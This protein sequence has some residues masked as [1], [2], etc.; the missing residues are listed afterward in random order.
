MQRQHVGT[1]AR[2]EQRVGYARAV[3]V[4]DRVLVSG[5]LAIDEN[6]EL[7]HPHSAHAQALHVLGIIESALQRLGATRA[8]V[9]R[10]RLYLLNMSDAD[11]VGLAHAEFF[12]S[13][14]PCATMVAVSALADPGARVE[15]EAEAIVGSGAPGSG[16][17][18][19]DAATPSG[20]PA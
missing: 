14:M 3:R 10:T 2:W 4:D 13:I 5:T 12:G 16:G 18:P 15:I 19:D 7:V 17:A 1:A 20:G 11:E 9:V 6:G 8:D